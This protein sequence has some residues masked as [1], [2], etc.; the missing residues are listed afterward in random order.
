M[1]PERGKAPGVEFFQI[2]L[3]RLE[4][5]WIQHVT[6]YHACAVELEEARS[7]HERAKADLELVVAELNIEVRRNPDSF[8]VEK[9]TEKVVESLV[10]RDSRYK[11]AQESLFTARDKV[12]IHQ[13]AVNTLEHKKKALENVVQLWLGNYFSKPKEPG[14]SHHMNKAAEDKAFRPMKGGGER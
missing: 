5:A 6:D 12:G 2:D 11:K 3:G 7:D 9:V 13:V 8:G 10:I 14:G 4:E 1:N